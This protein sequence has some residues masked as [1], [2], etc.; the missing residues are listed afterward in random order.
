MCIV[1]VRHFFF[2]VPLLL[3][4]GTSHYGTAQEPNQNEMPPQPAVAESDDKAET[5]AEMRAMA[6]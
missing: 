4:L 1:S 5:A 3:A 6:T 2:Y